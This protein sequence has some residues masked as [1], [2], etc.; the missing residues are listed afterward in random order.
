VA[1]EDSKLGVED[2]KGSS[3]SRS[4]S[5]TTLSTDVASPLLSS[6]MKGTLKAFAR[7]PHMVGSKTGLS[8]SESSS[9][10]SL[11]AAGSRLSP[12]SPESTDAETDDLIRRFTGLEGV[13]TRGRSHE[14]DARS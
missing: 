2:S 11:S 8:R 6:T 13:S 10:L 4:L 9:A 12:P 3:A 14:S 5:P 7:V 1:V